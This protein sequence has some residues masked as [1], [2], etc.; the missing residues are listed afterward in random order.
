MRERKYQVFVSSTYRGLE[1]ERRQVMHAL[2][3]MDCIPSGMELFPAADDDVWTLIESVIREADYYVLI[4]GGRYG[5]TDVD[6]VSYTEREYDFAVATGIPVLAFLHGDPGKIPAEL[7]DM[8]DEARAKLEAFRNKVENA[9]H[10]KYW[11]GAADLGGMVSRA[12][13]FMVKTKPRVGWVRADLAKT[14]EEVER[15]AALQGRVRE[16]EHHV[17]LLESEIADGTE[18]F[19]QGD[20]SVILR[21]LAGK[22]KSLENRRYTWNELFVPAANRAMEEPWEK[23]IVEAIERYIGGESENTGVTIAL[24]GETLDLIR[25]QFVALELIEIDSRKRKSTATSRGREMVLQTWVEL[26][27]ELTGK[28][29]RLL[30]QLTAIRRKEKGGKADKFN[31]RTG[32]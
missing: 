31:L 6:G 30:S 8:K 20:D 3:E 17:E 13:N 25:R 21:V 23:S 26:H 5:S 24:P 16:L 15:T 1:E 2:L 27:W 12:M 11:T 28:G 29:R 4:V 32:Q 10:C 14:V 7:S 19:A 22:D 9:H 18:V